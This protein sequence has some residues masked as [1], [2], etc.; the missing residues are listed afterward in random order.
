MDLLDELLT[1]THAPC[2]SYLPDFVREP[3]NM[4]GYEYCAGANASEAT[5]GAFGWSDESCSTMA[6]FMCKISGGGGW[7]TQQLC[8]LTPACVL[9][10]WVGLAGRSQELS[11]RVTHPPYAVAHGTPSDC[12]AVL[13]RHDT[14]PAATSC[15]PGGEADAALSTHARTCLAAETNTYSYNTST[16]T[17]FILHTTATDFNTA[18]RSCNDDG[19]HLAYYTS[20][21]EQQEVEQYFVNAGVFFPTFTPA[22]WMGLRSSKITWPTFEYMSYS[23]PAPDGDNYEHWGVSDL[24]REPDNRAGAEFCG[25]ANYTEIFSEA[26]GWA[27]N[28][29]TMP[30]PYICRVDGAAALSRSC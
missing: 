6:P 27:D 5:N 17:S 9:H 16:N 3:N 26:W 14:P 10:C 8:G 13:A 29:C 30:L 23:V 22:Y 28:N 24:W 2:C 18:E 25:A 19:G 12:L 11:D 1:T 21:S 20:M 7:G 15:C 4:F